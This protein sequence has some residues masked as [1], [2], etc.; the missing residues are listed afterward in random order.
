LEVGGIWW[1]DIKNHRGYL[2]IKNPAT[3]RVWEPPTDRKGTFAHWILSR[4]RLPIPTLWLK[5]LRSPLMTQGLLY[6][7]E[8]WLSRLG[9]REDK[10]L[11][12]RNV[13]EP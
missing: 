8:A 10:V 7:D 2:I 4:A 3:T 6:W 1:R 13:A 11:N 5:N 12:T 9:S